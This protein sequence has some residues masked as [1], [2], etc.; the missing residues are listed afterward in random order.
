[1]HE[2]R[3]ASATSPL[4]SRVRAALERGL[5][6]ESGG[7]LA[8]HG[9]ALARTRTA[10]ITAGRHAVRGGRDGRCRRAR[11]HSSGSR[12]R[13]AT[14]PAIASPRRG[15]P[16]PCAHGS[17]RAREHPTVRGGRVAQHRDR[18]R[19][20]TRASS[21]R[22]A[23]AVCSAAPTFADDDTRARAQWCLEQADAERTA[24]VTALQQTPD[25][26]AAAALHRA[27]ALPDVHGCSDPRRLARIP[28]PTDDAARTR[29]RRREPSWRRRASA[30]RRSRSAAMPRDSPIT[31]PRARAQPMSRWSA[32][33]PR[34]T[35][36]CGR[37]AR[38]T[39]SIR[40][41][42]G[43]SDVAE[44][45]LQRALGPRERPRRSDSA[46]PRCPAAALRH[47]LDRD[48]ADEAYALGDQ[49]GAFIYAAGDSRL[50]RA[51]L[52]NHLGTIAARDRRDHHDE[53]LAHHRDALVLGARAARRCPPGRWRR[54]RTSRARSRRQGVTT[55]RR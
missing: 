31:S 15:W 42:R 47:R 37:R 12:R 18:A 27:T 11:R 35:R 16:D 36:P 54:A 25:A 26:S 38:G 6:N 13:A 30:S 9:C 23:R 28:V 40:R 41:R 20:D 45:D 32:P 34:P 52:H 55:R 29:W 51:Q 53:A 39:C 48:R 46:R 5:A 19:M 49:I 43:D 44:S 3:R 1:M 8:R 7:A 2:G 4:P 33:P 22:S 21:M 24:L 17:G 50:L 14:R 10:A